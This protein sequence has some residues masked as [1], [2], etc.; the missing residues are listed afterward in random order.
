MRTTFGESFSE[1]HRI[2]W[3]FIRDNKLGHGIMAGLS[4]LAI[5]AFPAVVL[6]GIMVSQA[7]VDPAQVL[8]GEGQYPA[9]SDGAM[10]AAGLL[11]A[12]MTLG[13]VLAGFSLQIGFLRYTW[14][15]TPFRPFL[16]LFTINALKYVWRCLILMAIM[17]LVCA[18][19]LLVFV[20]TGAVLG[21]EDGVW[22][23]AVLGALA[24]LPA[25]Y[26][27]VR[28]APWT[29]TFADREGTRLRDG[30]AASS[31]AFWYVFWRMLIIPLPV[32]ILSAVAAFVLSMVSGILGMLL[33]LAGQI[34][35]A[36]V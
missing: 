16:N 15:D 12:V 29:A 20:G 11:Y 23:A 28:L 4:A 31:G 1:A 22:V 17:L 3:D 34:G 10:V 27:S 19:P 18:L 24:F 13:A 2:W 35:R 14:D 9:M 7:G 30:W 26:V 5:T 36:H 6:G 21:I 33:P 8:R 25:I 32:I